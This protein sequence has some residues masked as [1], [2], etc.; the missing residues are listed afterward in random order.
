MRAPLFLQIIVVL[1]AEEKPFSH[2]K[3]A[4]KAQVDICIHGD[5]AVEQEGEVINIDSGCR[6]HFA[7]RNISPDEKVFAQNFTGMDV[8]QPV[9]I[10][11]GSPRSGHLPRLH[12]TS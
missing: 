12:P 3:I 5:L 8:V 10:L 6:R 4:R 7:R 9:A 11:C 2:A 1:E